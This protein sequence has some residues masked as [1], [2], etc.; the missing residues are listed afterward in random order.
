MQP[1]AMGITQGGITSVRNSARPGTA[2]LSSVAPIRPTTSL[3]PTDSTI[4]RKVR[5]TMPQNREDSQSSR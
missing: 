2:A 4:H 3:S 5:A 1:M